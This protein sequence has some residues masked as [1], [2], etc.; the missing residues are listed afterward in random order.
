V[1][2]E[3]LHDVPTS[4]NG[5]GSGGGSRLNFDDRPIL[6]FWETTRACPLACRHCRAS[7]IH[8]PLPGEL[9][10]EEG[11]ALIDD[12]ATFGPRPP[13]LIMTGG[14]P[15]ARADLFELAGHASEVG[16]PI[17]FAP[18]VSP[19]LTDEAIE[20]MWDA[21]AKTVSISLDGATAHTHE[22]VRQVPGIF[23]DTLDAV[24]RLV[25]AGF[26][27]QIN[28]TVMRS[29]VQEL[30]GI[31]ALLVE[32]GARIWEVFFLIKTGR[33]TELEELTPEEN[34]D[35]S[36]FLYEASRYDFIVRTV[37]GPFFRRVAAWRRADDTDD[38]AGTYGLGSLYSQLSSRLRLV[39]GEPGVSRAQTAG[40]R[41]GKGIVFVAHNG[42]VFPSGF[43]P[44]V[45]GN[46]RDSSIVE[47][48]RGHPLLRSI[49]S[50]AFTGRC[51]ACEF[52]DMCGGS[53]SRAFA[54]HGDPLADD[55]GCSHLTRSRTV[56]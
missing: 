39:L 46:V 33:G 4:S 51:G 47:L 18:A 50:A 21:G 1:G 32:L 22:D 20:K 29:N 34:E 37:E 24:R 16:M 42:D 9:T 26:T 48:Y 5:H 53:R 43:L 10:T 55:P 40:T 52:S 36:H 6:V 49:R 13:V 45:L 2:N 7:A 12:I 30:P 19:N 31:A 17:G 28:T 25:A 56:P 41:D 23:A 27:V 35:V 15:L 54:A 11:H 3:V 44:T 14:D 8:T 38:P